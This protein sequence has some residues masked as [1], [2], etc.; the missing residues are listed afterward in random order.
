LGTLVRLFKSGEAM[1][2]DGK[3]VIHL[4]NCYLAFPYLGMMRQR[5]R[6]MRRAH[7]HSWVRWGEGAMLASADAHQATLRSKLP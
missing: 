2:T 4:T 7:F 1:N 6:L 5:I 3:L